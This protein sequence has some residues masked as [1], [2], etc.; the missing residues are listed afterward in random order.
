MF[1]FKSPALA[2]GQPVTRSHASDI[3][4]ATAETTREEEEEAGLVKVADRFFVSC[5]KQR[6]ERDEECSSKY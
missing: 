4:R 1:F 3:G 5:H 6:Q 2:L